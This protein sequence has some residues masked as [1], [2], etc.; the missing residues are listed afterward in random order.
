VTLGILRDLPLLLLAAGMA[1]PFAIA[2]PG[3]I[4]L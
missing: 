2:V 1:V 4:Y 3:V